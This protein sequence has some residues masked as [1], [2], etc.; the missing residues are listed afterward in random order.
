VDLYDG[1]GARTPTIIMLE[2][3]ERREKMEKVITKLDEDQVRHGHIKTLKDVK[4]VDTEITE[5]DVERK[6][7]H[8]MFRFI[9]SVE[10]H[11]RWFTAKFK[12]RDKKKSKY[13][14]GNHMGKKTLILFMIMFS[15]GVIPGHLYGGEYP[16]KTIELY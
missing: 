14:E 6:G 8:K 7:D 12:E 10:V 9:F 13:E 1:I 16:T 11:A 2:R 15:L 3:K 5:M 4:R